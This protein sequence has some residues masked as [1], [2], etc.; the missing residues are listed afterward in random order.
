MDSAKCSERNIVVLGAIATPFY[1]TAPTQS[2]QRSPQGEGILFSPLASLK[3]ITEIVIFIGER[4]GN[5]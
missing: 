1:P 5:G 2:G 3:I 4:S